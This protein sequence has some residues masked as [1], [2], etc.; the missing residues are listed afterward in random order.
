MKKIDVS[1]GVFISCILLMSFINPDDWF[2]FEAKNCKIYFPQKPTEQSQTIVTAIGE[3]KLNIY[4]YQ[5][6]DNKEDDNLVYG[7]I[8]SDYPD[9]LINSNKKDIL[10][11]FFR[12]SIDGAVNNVHGKLLSE[13]KIQLDSFP[14]RE[15]RIDFR[16][17]LAVLKM[18]IY[19][20]RNKMYMEQTITD[21]KKDFNKSIDRFM[22]S[23]KLV[24]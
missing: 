17:G 7:L 4:M 12:N 21:T 13:S 14:G 8:E 16:D 3:L 18:R 20:V 15:V 9:S 11:N 2:L 1:I 24:N 5:V 22:D 19:L 23:F 6:P 10:D